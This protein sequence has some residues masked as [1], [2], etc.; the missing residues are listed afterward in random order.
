MLEKLKI[1]LARRQITQTALAKGVQRSDS[2][3]SRIVRGQVRCRARLRRLISSYLGVNE[4]KIFPRRRSR[5]RS[6]P[7]REPRG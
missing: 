2:Q 5:R 1:E 7:P 4:H 3:I 6:A